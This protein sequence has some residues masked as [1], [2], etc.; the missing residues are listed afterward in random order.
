MSEEMKQ[1]DTGIRNEKP[2]VAQLDHVDMKQV[3]PM[4]ATL[5]GCMGLLAVALLVAHQTVVV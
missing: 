4:L 2:A 3:K 5:V 1:A